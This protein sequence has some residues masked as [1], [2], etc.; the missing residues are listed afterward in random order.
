MNKASS[1]YTTGN[2]LLTWYRNELAKYFKR[3]K[4]KILDLGCGNGL[5]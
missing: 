2:Y 1:R 3:P 5:L 4:G